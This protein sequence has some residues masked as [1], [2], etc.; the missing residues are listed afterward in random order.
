MTIT[1]KNIYILAKNFYLLILPL[2]Y[3]GFAEKV[4]W[5]QGTVSRVG[6]ELFFLGIK[7]KCKVF[8]FP[9]RKSLHSFYM[10]TAQTL[11]L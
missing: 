10:K 7:L 4:V 2:N 6:W 9:P 1:A 5:E 8:E 11:Y 3:L